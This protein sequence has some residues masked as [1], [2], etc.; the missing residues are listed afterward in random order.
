[1]KLKTQKLDDYNSRVRVLEIQKSELE[2]EI[3]GKTSAEEIEKLTAEIASLNTE[4]QVLSENV[5]KTRSDYERFL[6]ANKQ[7]KEFSEN[8]EK[9]KHKYDLAKELSNVLKGKALAEYVAEEYLQ[10]ITVSAN[11]KLALLM[12]GRYTL[13]F[14]NKEFVVEDNFNDAQ[15]RPAS[16]LSGGE[17]FLVSLSLALSISEAI[18]MLSS[19]SM[20]FFFLDEGFGTLDGEL[21]EAVVGALYKLESR[22]LKIGLISHVKEL[23]DSI[24]NKV[25]IEKTQNKGSIIRIDHTL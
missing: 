18:T 3:S 21:C 16:T 6:I 7:Y 20:D 10:E 17:T 11:E 12:D 24:K 25:L 22:N 23:E 9:Y 13:K 8:L 5:G 4:V 1:M 15:V 14:E 19:R 2:S